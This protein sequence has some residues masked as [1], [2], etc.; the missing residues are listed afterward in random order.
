MVRNFWFS[1]LLGV[2]LAGS[3]MVGPAFSGENPPPAELSGWN[4]VSE[5]ELLGQSASVD[6]SF[7]VGMSNSATMDGDIEDNVISGDTDTG[8]ISA[9]IVQN[10]QGITTV[11][12]NTG[13]QVNMGANVN[14]NVYMH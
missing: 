5:A 3:A 11:L 7:N 9:S 12:Q 6:D 14:V 10:N 1:I 8:N 13:N 4:A 2:G